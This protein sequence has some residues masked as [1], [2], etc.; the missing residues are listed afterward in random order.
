MNILNVHYV[1][2]D[3]L[4]ALSLPGKEKDLQWLSVHG[5]MM[6]SKAEKQTKGDPDQEK[7][8]TLAN[9]KE[10]IGCILLNY[11]GLQLQDTKKWSSIFGLND[12]HHGGIY[13]LI[14]V[15]AMKL[16]LASHTVA[17]DACVVPLTDKIMPKLEPGIQKLVNHRFIQVVT[18]EDEKR[19]WK[20]LLPVIA[21]RCRTWKHTDTCEYRT[22]G[23]PVSVEGSERS[24]LCS[25]GKG[26]NLGRFGTLSD[27]KLFHGEATRVAIGPLFTFSFMEELSEAVGN[28]V[29]GK[30]T[31]KMDKCAKCGGPGKPN[32]LLCSVC[33]V[34]RYCSR[35]CQKAHWKI[36]K[37]SCIAAK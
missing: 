20:L 33:K 2:L 26:K 9:L 13:T 7:R 4:P 18:L 28:S 11:A 23:V 35:D 15:N 3:I 32:L 34:A 25:C 14:F 21:E 30:S 31:H 36:H 12:P 22:S 6:F 19:T 27:W 10:S 1:N 24:P 37:K 5:G 29:I 17:L 8:G 16:D